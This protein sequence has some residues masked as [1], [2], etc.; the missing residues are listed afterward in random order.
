MLHVTVM[1]FIFNAEC[2]EV[3][4]TKWNILT[5]Q[6]LIVGSSWQQEEPACFAGVLF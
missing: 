3:N 2:C 1:H 5:G 6:Y 4:S